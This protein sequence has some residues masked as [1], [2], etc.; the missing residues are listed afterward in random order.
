MKHVVRY[1][2]GVAACGVLAFNAAPAAAAE[3]GFEVGARLGYGIA[4]GDAAEGLEMGDFVSG[5]IPLWLDVGYRIMPA[6]MVG[7]YLQYGFGILGG[8]VSDACDATGADC[9]ASV[10]RL[11]AQGQYHFMPWEAVDPWV[12]LGIGYEWASQSIG[13]A[14][15]GARG[16]E[17]LNLQGGADFAV[18]DGLAVGPFLSFSLGQYSTS[19]VEDESSDIEETAMHQWLTFGVRGTFVP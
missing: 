3:E 1:L 13:D 10:V 6:L 14:S 18:A 9:S 4:M 11:G 19:W 7:G 17:F 15:F 5:Q 12:G 8:D 16:F 2:T